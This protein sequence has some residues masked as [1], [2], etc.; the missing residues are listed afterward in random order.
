MV[1]GEE[2]PVNLEDA[3]GK[4]LFEKLKAQQDVFR[5]KFEAQCAGRNSYV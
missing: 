4:D 2:S 1:V 5:T 3:I